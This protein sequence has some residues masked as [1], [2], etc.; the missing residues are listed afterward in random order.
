M[1]Q[2]SAFQAV[3][4]AGR[5]VGLLLFS[6]LL[7]FFLLSQAQAQQ[8][9][10][11]I[12]IEGVQPVESGDQF[13]AT[14]L[15]ENVEHLAGFDFSIGYDPERVKPVETGAS[16][17][18]PLPENVVLIE[19]VDV[20]QVITQNGERQDMICDTPKADSS[21][22]TAT[23]SCVTV[24][25]PLCLGGDAGASGSGVLGRVV[26]ESKGGGLTTLEITS[27]TL[28]LDDYDICQVQV[29]GTTDVLP[30]NCLPFREEADPSAPE[31]SCQPDGTVAPV[32]EL[33]IEVGGQSWVHAQDLGWATS[34][35]LQ[36]AG[37]VAAIQSRSE[38][39]T[40]EL[41]GGGGSNTV[42]IVVAVGVG[43]A[44]VIIALG[45]LAW[46][47]RRPASN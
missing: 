25:P 3:R 29:A 7:A 22:S 33:P 12:Q 17:D 18:T 32:A 47:R 23:V 2:L 26:F 21:Q 10:V 34:D 41:S 31:L 6:A 40:V 37:T 42:V 38:D 36:A 45:G 15:V 4:R 19:A 39:A 8:T 46:Y 27:S 35:Y 44:V 9:V 43:A 16:G 5:P 13:Q 14:V 30:G 11:R 24:G 1:G 28:V 20:G